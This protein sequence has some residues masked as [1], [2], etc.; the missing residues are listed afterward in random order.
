MVFLHPG[1]GRFQKKPWEGWQSGLMMTQESP[2]PVTTM[3]G[4]I[5][6][7]RPRVSHMA[8]EPHTAKPCSSCKIAI[9]LFIS[10]KFLCCDYLHYRYPVNK[11]AI[12]GRLCKQK[13][14]TW[15]LLTQLLPLQKMMSN[16]KKNP[17]KHN[18]SRHILLW[19]LRIAFNLDVTAV[20]LIVKSEWRNKYIE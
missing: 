15:K 9:L 12:F 3:R 14:G 4:T 18:H 10:L 20:K 6:W 19:I 13:R 5:L 11:V 16:I 17:T 7:R 8:F 1:L 2:C